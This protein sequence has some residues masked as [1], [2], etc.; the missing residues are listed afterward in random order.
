MTSAATSKESLSQQIEQ[1]RK[2]AEEA[3]K[4]LNYEFAFVLLDQVE[5][6]EH[7]L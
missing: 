3:K 7:Q 2:E 4:A 6:L 5:V 1:L